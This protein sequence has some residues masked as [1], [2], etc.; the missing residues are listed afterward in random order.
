MAL[1]KDE[2]IAISKKIVSIP[3]ENKNSDNTTKQ[4][5]A[6]LVDAQTKDT[7]NKGL[8]ERLDPKIN[9]YQNEKEILD[10]ATLL[11][12]SEQNIV[13]AANKKLQNF[14]FPNDST[15]PLPSVPDGI[16]KNFQSFSGTV[17]IGRKY[18][19]DNDT[20]DNE[21]QAIVDIL[22]L[23]AT[24]ESNTDVTRVTGESCTTE[25]IPPPPT[26]TVDDDPVI[27]QL[28]VDLKARVDN[29]QSFHVLQ[30]AAISGNP[31]TDSGNQV[32]NQTADDDI[33][34]NITPALTTWEAYQD[35]DPQGGTSCT[36]FNSIDINTLADTK[37]KPAMLSALKT[38]IQTRQTFV[39]TRVSQI[40]GN[41]GGVTQAANGDINATTGFYGERFRL[42]ELRLN[43]MNG[44]LNTV[45]GLTKAI[46]AQGQ[47]KKSNENAAIAYSSVISVSS[48]TSKTNGSRYVNV[49][50]ASIFS[51]KDVV[52][53]K[54]VGKPEIQTS[55]VGKVGNRLEVAKNITQGYN[56]E[57]LGRVYKDLT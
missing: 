52:Y 19:E 6:V 45:T 10:G 28:L 18:T 54:A 7:S 44:S 41:L 20:Q 33:D 12:L 4:L 42:I 36:S 48:I 55:I 38:A 37:L 27:Q 35:F 22:A 31:D 51:I 30:K 2:R 53:I 34:N 57:N 39:A 40:A 25:P 32:E 56:L 47:A 43:L 46:D 26:D 11:E 1:S 9:S 15:V 3:I 49:K 14:F 21:Q 13:D 29:L 23:I 8:I 17:A 50:D 16:W 5:E 24:A